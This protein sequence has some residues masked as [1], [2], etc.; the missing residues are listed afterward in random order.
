MA[1]LFTQEIHLS[2]RHEE[3]LSQRLMLLQKMK[4]KFGDENT[5]RASLLQATETA[6]RR[7]LRL[8]KD[9]DAAEEAFQTK[10]IPHPQPS[11]LSLETRYWAS[12]EEHIPKWELFLLGR[13]P[14]PIGAENQNEVPF[15]QTEAKL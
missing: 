1:S 9:I 13:A 3:I 14:Y 4:N 15:V 7:N 10:L 2:K 8:L 11:M 5:E 12:V 6:S